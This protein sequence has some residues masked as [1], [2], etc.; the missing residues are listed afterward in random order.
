MGKKGESLHGGLFSFLDAAPTAFQAATEIMRRLE[1]AR[2]VRL[3]ER[4]EWT[5]KPGG[6]YFVARNDSS[7]IVFRVGRKAPHES[8]FMM[9]GAHTDSPLLK[10]KPE[11]ESAVR[12]METLVTAISSKTGL[13]M[14]PLKYAD[15]VRLEA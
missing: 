3:D 14:D 2:F 12:K 8:G 10:I 1:S 7:V 4:Q 15:A 13:G 11:A 5:L 6:A 9:A